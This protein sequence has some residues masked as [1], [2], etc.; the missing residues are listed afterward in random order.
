MGNTENGG[1]NGLLGPSRFSRHFH[2]GGELAAEDLAKDDF[3]KV[4]TKAYELGDSPGHR[5]VIAHEFFH[6]G[7]GGEGMLPAAHDVKA[8]LG[9]G[10]E[11]FKNSNRAD[12][13]AHRAGADVADRFLNSAD[14]GFLSG[15]GG[16]VGDLDNPGGEERV[17]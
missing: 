7:G 14:A 13:V 5:A 4:M 15:K 6:D 16:G 8:I 3:A 1:L 10:G 2:A 17:F 11:G 12:D 9:I